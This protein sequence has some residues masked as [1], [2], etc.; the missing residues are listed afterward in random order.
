MQEEITQLRTKLN[1]LR[2]ERDRQEQNYQEL[3][4]NYSVQIEAFRQQTLKLQDLDRNYQSILDE[5]QFLQQQNS[6][7]QSENAKLQLQNQ[8]IV[9]KYTELLEQNKLSKDS[10]HKQQQT[11]HILTQ[12]I[13]HL[14]KEYLNVDE[15]LSNVNKERSELKKKGREFLE[16]FEISKD[17][18]KKINAQIKEFFDKIPSSIQKDLQNISQAKSILTELLESEDI[19]LSQQIQANFEMF[20]LILSDSIFVFKR[21]SDIRQ[22]NRILTQKLS[23]M[24]KQFY[25]FNNEGEEWKE[26]EKELLIKIDELQQEKAHAQKQSQEILNEMNLK[27]NYYAQNKKQMALLFSENEKQKNQIFNQQKVIDKLRT[28]TI[29][30]QQQ[31]LSSIENKMF[32]NQ[33]QLVVS[34]KKKIEY[35]INQIVS[36]IQNEKLQSHIN[37]ILEH[38]KQKELISKQQLEYESMLQKYETDL[39]TTVKNNPLCEENITLRKNLE[40]I[41]QKFSKSAQAIRILE[42]KIEKEINQIQRLEFLETQKQNFDF[43]INDVILNQLIINNL[44]ISNKK[45]VK[46]QLNELKNYAYS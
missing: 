10:L 34:E 4:Q 8:Q 27:E 7:F 23:N 9:Q 18:I 33:Y 12:K 35:I 1:D 40:N 17:Q 37:E 11:H 28:Q 22:E 29:D 20:S 42:Q 24:E 21:Y 13:N 41:R 14:Q 32:E 19:G 39:K 26:R 3:H 15:H 36:K 31:N 43:K 6:H 2:Q 44:F 45:Q 25:S 30:I 46:E 16:D 5:N 38:N